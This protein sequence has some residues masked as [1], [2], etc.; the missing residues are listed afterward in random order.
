MITGFGGPTPDG[1]KRS[2]TG[3][4]DWDLRFLNNRYGIEGFA[5]FT[6]QRW[7]LTAQAPST[8]FAGKMWVR[9]RLGTV[10]GFAGADVYSDAFNPN[11]IGQLRENNFTAPLSDFD[12]EI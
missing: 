11:D 10:T 8:G 2:L 1:R 4:T 12:Y 3:G 6:H 9:K 7:T 5:A